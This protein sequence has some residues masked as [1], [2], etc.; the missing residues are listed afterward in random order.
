MMR[1]QYIRFLHTI[2]S[3]GR[4]SSD[5]TK[6]YT[7]NGSGPLHEQMTEILVGDHFV[8]LRGKRKDIHGKEY[9]ATRITPLTNVRDFEEEP[10][11]EDEPVRA[12][13]DKR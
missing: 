11:T 1:A 5:I 7:H 3:P 12:S 4:G 8:V 13:K 9:I 2:M 6:A 10:I